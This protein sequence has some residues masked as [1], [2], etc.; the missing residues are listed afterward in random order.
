[1]RQRAKPSFTVEVKR[2]NKIT[3][4]SMIPSGALN[5]ETYRSA[6]AALFGPS[7]MVPARDQ[8][9][10]AGTFTNEGTGSPPSSPPA[11]RRVLPDLVAADLM[12][13]RAREEAAQRE[14]QER[15]VR[16]TRVKTPKKRTATRV[17]PKLE[18]GTDAVEQ[19]VSPMASH[20]S[21]KAA[22]RVSATEAATSVSRTPAVANVFHSEARVATQTRSR[23]NGADHLKAGERW[24]RRLPKYARSP[25]HP[26]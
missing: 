1:V 6:E 13:T 14:T 21:V 12:A 3:R 16:V 20:Q 7:P 24:K 22:D 23:R 2:G 15:T 5:R 9:V 18:P 11:A 4:A 19:H 25:K 26:S 8:S 17:A 10:T